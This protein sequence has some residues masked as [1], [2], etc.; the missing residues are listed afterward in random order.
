MIKVVIDTNVI[1]SALIKPNSNPETI[2]NLLLKHKAFTLCTTE[3]IIDEYIKVF[4]YKKLKKYLPNK[5]VKLFLKQLT[6]KSHI[7]KQTSDIPE[8]N[9]KDDTKFLACAVYAKANYLVTG[10][11]KDFPKGKYKNV[12]IVTPTEFL[13]RFVDL[14]VKL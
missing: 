9:D 6:L 14:N 3:E 11:I 1:V 8:L 12:A 4:Q 10:N 2:I 7:L 5:K 13:H